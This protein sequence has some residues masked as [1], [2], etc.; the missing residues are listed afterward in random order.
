MPLP[1]ALLSLRVRV[2]MELS[3]NFFP[4]SFFFSAF[5]FPSPFSS[6]TSPAQLAAHLSLREAF[7]SNTGSTER[8]FGVL[9]LG[10]LPKMEGWGGRKM[11]ESSSS[12]PR[13]PGNIIRSV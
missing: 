4:L 10:T 1:S 8:V 3:S 13:S 12:H 5:P 11:P 9:F 2:C 6:R 7:G